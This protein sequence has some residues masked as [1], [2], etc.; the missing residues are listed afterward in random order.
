VS[1]RRGPLS[2]GALWRGAPSQGRFSL[3]RYA[4][5]PPAA[6]GTRG[7]RRGG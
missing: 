2:R 1:G 4:A 7:P 3:G 5:P 6:A